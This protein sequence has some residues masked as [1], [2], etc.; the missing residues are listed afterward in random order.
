MN[1]DRRGGREG[2][3]SLRVGKKAQIEAA[4]A[5]ET[6]VKNARVAIRP[7]TSVLPPLLPPLFCQSP[8]GAHRDVCYCAESSG[9][10]DG[11]E[12]E[13]RK[14]VRVYPFVDCRFQ[15]FNRLFENDSLRVLSRLNSSG[16]LGAILYNPD[17]SKAS[18]LLAF[19]KA[20]N[21]KAAI[22]MENGELKEGF[23]SF[24]AVVGIHPDN[25]KRVSNIHSFSKQMEELKDFA[26]SAETVAVMAGLD[27]S[28]EKNTYF[29]QEKLVLAHMDLAKELH[30]PIIIEL[31][32]AEAVEK[33][34]EKLIELNSTDQTQGI[35]I[36]GFDLRVGIYLI[37]PIMS[38]SLKELIKLNCYF[39]LDAAFMQADQAD[40]WS[41]FIPC[42]PVSQVLM[43]SNSPY[44]TPQN[45]EDEWIRKGRNEPSNFPFFIKAL[46][47]AFETT[48]A[49]FARQCLENA[50]LYFQLSHFAFES[51]RRYDVEEKKKVVFV[52]SNQS[53]KKSKKA[54]KSKKFDVHSSDDFDPIQEQLAA[55][56]DDDELPNYTKK[57]K[58]KAAFKENDLS[59]S[60]NE[61]GTVISD[62]EKSSLSD[63]VQ[64]QELSCLI[65]SQDTNNS[66]KIIL[67]SGLDLKLSES[68]RALQIESVELAREKIQEEE[69]FERER[70]EAKRIK[71]DSKKKKVAPSK[72][73][74][75]SSFRNK[76][77]N[78][79]KG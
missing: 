55:L 2:K 66:E 76:D 67:R 6:Q 16:C 4:K 5:H 45:I 79:K 34:V 74:N 36:G 71:K 56:S 30:L 37:K 11:K 75:F 58:K 25:I 18:E 57:I 26:L 44:F 69:A 42:V 62:S 13:D 68:L 59:N 52:E 64:K 7:L 39:L 43:C 60:E 46:A 63:S 70:E 10:V 3:K 31:N 22:V 65:L 12:K 15:L 50:K 38:D 14:E 53:K 47:A 9:K 72:T 77:Y 40:F 54:K 35:G 73:A 33:L 61:K 20:E 78:N 48:E 27:F 41:E 28:R 23:S 8:T 49:A 17:F 51:N 29:L 24:Y 19:C 32:G 21:V 1:V